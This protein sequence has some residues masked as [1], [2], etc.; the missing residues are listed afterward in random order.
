MRNGLFLSSARYVC[1]RNRKLFETQK[2]ARVA[3]GKKRKKENGIKLFRFFG[4]R[5][6]RSRHSDGKLGLFVCRV[7]SVQNAF[8]SSRVA[9]FIAVISETQVFYHNFFINA[10]ILKH[11]FPNCAFF[12]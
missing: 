4:S 9:P 5:F 6:F 11:N 7:V 2:T 1:V 10:S 12:T 3:D 8:G